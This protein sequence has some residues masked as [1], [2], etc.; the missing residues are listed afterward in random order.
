MAQK[1][2]T[3][4]LP[5][6]LIAQ[7]QFLANWQRP[8]GLRGTDGGVLPTC[9]PAGWPAGKTELVRGTLS[10]PFLTPPQ[11]LITVSRERGSP[12][13][14]QLEWLLWAAEVLGATQ[15]LFFKGHFHVSV[16]SGSWPMIS[17][18]CSEEEL[19]NPALY[20]PR[21][22]LQQGMVGSMA[23]RIPE[24]LGTPE[25]QAHL[26]YQLHSYTVPPQDNP[27][28]G[29]SSSHK[30]RAT[31]DPMND[32]PFSS[33]ALL[34]ILEFVFFI[35]T[36]V[37]Q[38]WMSPVAQKWTGDGHSGPR[39]PGASRASSDCSRF[40]YPLAMRNGFLSLVPR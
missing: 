37:I 23:P 39:D 18:L 19:L 36:S 33:V 11:Q 25:N 5:A 35:H 32:G 8:L 30:E 16:R 3:Q 6:E 38:T 15:E 4:A 22:N 13:A 29:H 17:M 40:S 12:S 27:T 7:Q 21:G 24:S 10:F 9:V 26:L 14:C 2:G 20:S 1:P 31:R 28:M 34:W